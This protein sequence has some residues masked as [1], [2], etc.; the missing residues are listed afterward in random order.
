MSLKTPL[1]C[2]MIT[3]ASSRSPKL[4]YRPASLGFINGPSKV[5]IK[6][7]IFLKTLKTIQRVQFPPNL[8]KDY[9]NLIK[10]HNN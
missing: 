9:C 10:G 8:L 6:P 4:A 3:T 2:S 1:T 5:F 7:T